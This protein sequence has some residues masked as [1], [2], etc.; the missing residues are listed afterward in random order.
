MNGQRDPIGIFSTHPVAANLLMTMMVLAGLW[1][2]RG[3][4]TQFLPSF[5]IDYATVVTAWS[6]ASAVDVEELITISLE[7]E[8]RDVDYVKQITSTSSEGSSA[9]LLEFEEGT[10][11]ALAVSRVKERVDLVRNLPAS[12]ETPEV[13]KVADYGNVTSLLVAGAD[14]VDELR[15]LV[16]RFEQELLERGIA[17]IEISGLPK[18]E[19]AIEIPTSE[20]RRL[21]LSLEEI[22]RRVSSWSQ[23]VPVGIVGQGDTARQLRFR[24]RRKDELEFATIPVIAEGGGRR[25]SL[26]D[27]ANIERRQRDFEV[28]V[29]YRG[30]PAVV[31]DLK[32]TDTSDA[33]DAARIFREWLD[34]TRP[35]LPDGIELVPF[36]EEWKLISGRINTLIK[37]GAG[38]LVL[39]VLMLFLF[40]SGRVAWWTAVG[41]PI[42]FMAALAALYMFGGSINMLSLFGLIMAL[43]IIVDDAIVVGEEAMTRYEQGSRPRDASANA[44]RQMLGPVLSSSLTT[45]AAFMP[46]LIVGGVIGS[47]MKTIPIV[48]ICVILASL[49]EC[50]LI[51]PGH[52][53]HSFRGMKEYT[54][55]KT[56]QYLDGLFDNFRENYFRPAVTAA[57]ANRWVTLAAV[58]TSLLVTVGWA[59]SGRI[60]FSFFPTAEEE[61]IYANVGFV[62]GAP[63]GEVREYLDEV[64]RALLEVESDYGRELIKFAYVLRGQTTGEN[65]RYGDQFGSVVAQLT[66]PDKRALRNRDITAA[67]KAKLPARPGVESLTILE[68]RAGPPGRDFE[69]LVSGNGIE[70]VKRATQELQ[71]ILADIAGVSGIGD[72]SP[73]GREQMVL[74]LTPTAE[75]LGLSVDNVSRQLRAAYDGYEVQEISD[76]YDA[77]KVRLMLSGAERDTAAGLAT[78]PVVLPSGNIE[79]VGGLATIS[80]EQG[81]ESIRRS[82]GKLTVTVTASVDDSVNNANRI[83]RE[84]ETGVLPEL[85]TRHGVSFSFEGSQADQDETLGDMKFGM[86]LGL[87]LIYLVLAWVFGSYGWPLVVMF[88]IPF[89]MVGAVWGHVLM[90]QNITI[91]SL[92]GFFA[93]SGIVVNDSII[94]VV[95]YKKL[96]EKG[97]AARG[98][99]IDA[100]CRRLRPVLLTSLT[101][102]SGLLPLL[103]ETSLQA[104]FLIPMA[105][106]I[107]FGLAFATLLVLFV[108]P[109]LLLMYENAEQEMRK[110]IAARK[111]Q[112][113]AF[114]FRA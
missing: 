53:T 26:G 59:A 30:K 14:E 86:L 97:A 56:R 35:Q 3:L 42:S 94:L 80:R 24:E 18:E 54:P 73:Y 49:I 19:I 57:L 6:G 102:I 88:I 47:I 68:P 50:F 4:N 107:S 31:M 61:Q 63:A 71:N 60:Q 110:K 15:P 58:V 76:G 64:E 1:G 67:W 12:A 10:D 44:A 106:T 109:A 74:Q 100:A 84:L 78:L 8:L 33:L 69:L 48:V 77:I 9:V 75:A 40:M 25:L 101:T 111:L 104:Q 13:S 87:S 2:I 105:T 28:T 21:G 96:R 22:G 92:F 20:L 99:L 70:Q 55:G 46:L 11:M 39:V 85:A 7:Q 93:L 38:G 37:N 23:N 114:K 32:R 5:D 29:R 27:I 72:D 113:K 36:E 83:R 95:Y 65:A 34:E 66:D 17:K 45:I 103:F 90:G 41:I 43:G 82:N 89:G 108:I 62:A 51:L 52:L 81:F 79:S 98:A 16:R 91:L 112:F